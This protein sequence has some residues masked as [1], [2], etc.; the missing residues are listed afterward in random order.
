MPVSTAWTCC[1]VCA[2]VVA[3][4]PAHAAWH[5]RNNDTEAPDA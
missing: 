1:P 5:A 2:A 3:D 4:A